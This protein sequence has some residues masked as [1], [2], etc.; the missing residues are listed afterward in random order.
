M[1]DKAFPYIIGIAAI[2]VG[3]LAY[4]HGTAAGTYDNT[5]K[6]TQLYTSYAPLQSLSQITTVQ[7][8]LPYYPATMNTNASVVARGNEYSSLT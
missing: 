8:A 4:K 5:T 3:Y 6:T 1:I 7:S 2:W